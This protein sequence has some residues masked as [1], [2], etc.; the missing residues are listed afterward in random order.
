MPYLVAPPIF[1]CLLFSILQ[2]PPATYVSLVLVPSVL[3]NTLVALSEN[4]PLSV[5]VALVRFHVTGSSD[6]TGITVTL[7]FAESALYSSLPAA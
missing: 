5:Y 7:T 2:L 4:E 1:I 6:G 3:T